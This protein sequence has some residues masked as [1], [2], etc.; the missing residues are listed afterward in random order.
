VT[1]IRVTLERALAV[2]A[3]AAPETGTE[4]VEVAD[5]AG[6][7]LAVDV[8]AVRDLPAA[9]VAAMDGWAVRAADTPGLL[10]P[11]GESAAGA[12]GGRRLAAG[13]AIAISTGALLPPGADAVARIEITSVDGAM[14]RVREA[15]A[16][17]RDVR[18]GGE[19]IRAG[20][21]LLRAGHRVRAHEVGAVGAVGLARV[22]CARRPRVAVLA[23]GAELVPLGADARPQE[24]HD[25]SRVG[26]AAQLAAAGAEVVAGDAVGDDLEATVG[27][28][29]ALLAVADVVAS[30][31][32]ISA[33]WHDLVRAALARLGAEE[34]VRGVEASPMRPTLIA[35]HGR[36]I[37]LGLPGNP[38]SAAIA[39]HLLGRPLLGAPLGW[40][41][42]PL[43]RDAGGH[44]SRPS[45]LRCAEG[46]EG[47][48]PLPHQGAHAI[49]S[50]AGADVVAVVPAGGARAGA[51]VAVSPL[52]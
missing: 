40:R 38:A 6:R 1:E 43:T 13:E 39:A 11:A 49:T 34:I 28:L 32:G 2:A 24:V 20:G 7:R 51:P 18:P 35:R 12:P 46:P 50:L 21:V 17:G 19:L 27:A 14:V 41:R 31:G 47:I 8:V 44:P 42:A 16:P 9:A 4:P 3:Q 26:V 15:V 25:S 22:K 37:V 30:C 5:L 33:G 23:T 48:A 45:L 10:R 36:R 52:P 29:R